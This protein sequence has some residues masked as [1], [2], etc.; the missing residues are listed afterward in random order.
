MRHCLKQLEI[1]GIIIQILGVLIIAQRCR[2]KTQSKICLK[3]KG[4]EV[5]PGGYIS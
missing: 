3:I 2:S 4:E 1:F 5:Q